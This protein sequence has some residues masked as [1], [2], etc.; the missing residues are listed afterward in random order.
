MTNT[1]TTKIVEQFLSLVPQFNQLAPEAIAEIASKLK[2]IRFGVGK[3]M[4]MRE[5]MQ[6]QVAIIS[7]GEVRL[8]GYDLKCRPLWINSNQD[9]SLVG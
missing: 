4:I 8:L 3:V 2:P 5:K 7:E 6:G 1:N 9:R